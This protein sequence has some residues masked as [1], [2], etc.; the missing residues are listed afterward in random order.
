MPVCLHVLGAERA[1]PCDKVPAYPFFSPRLA[2]CMCLLSESI[3]SF[4]GTYDTPA[5]TGDKK[6]LKD[7]NP[8]IQILWDVSPQNFTDDLYL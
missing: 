5:H 8:C 1:S 6:S 2:D 7:T 3:F 4:T